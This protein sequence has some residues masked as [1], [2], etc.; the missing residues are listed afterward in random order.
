[1]QLSIEPPAHAGTGRCD[2]GCYFRSQGKILFSSVTDK[3][4]F[5]FYK[6]LAFKYELTT[7]FMLVCSYSPASLLCLLKSMGCSVKGYSKPWFLH[8]SSTLYK[9]LWGYEEMVIAAS[10]DPQCFRLFLVVCS[11]LTCWVKTLALL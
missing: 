5:L 1:M 4:I 7:G 8:G 2:A 10:L 3:L 11:L 6:F 9:L